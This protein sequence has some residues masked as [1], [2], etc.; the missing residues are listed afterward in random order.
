MDLM[1]ICA[2]ASFTLHSLPSPPQNLPSL[3]R[4]L[5][6][7]RAQ[8]TGPRNEAVP[9]RTN[10]VFDGRARN[11]FHDS[12][13]HHTTH[14]KNFPRPMD[15][16]FTLDPDTFLSIFHAPSSPFALGHTGAPTTSRER[17]P[18]WEPRPSPEKPFV[19]LML[20]TRSPCCG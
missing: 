10:G 20:S 14:L 1:E 17:L 7:L 11:N 15:L 2:S 9:Q 3:Q 13:D 16:P 8:M 4:P 18:A 6:N 19:S 12:V 5:C